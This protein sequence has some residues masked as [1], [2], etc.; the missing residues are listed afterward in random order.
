M[1]KKMLPVS[2]LT[3]LTLCGCNSSSAETSI[4]ATSTG[5]SST[6]LVSYSDYE[7][8]TVTDAGKD[9]GTSLENTILPT[10][11]SDFT[12]K[13][14]Y[15]YSYISDYSS[16]MTSSIQT[17]M[18]EESLPSIYTTITSAS[19]TITAPGD[20]YYS[21]SS[22]TD[23]TIT[24]ATAGSVHIYLDNATITAS[25][26]AIQVSGGTTPSLVTITALPNS[27]N[28]ITASEAKAKNA[29]DISSDLVVNGTGT[30]NVTSNN[31]CIKSSKTIYLKDVSLNL[32]A[33]ADLDGHG[34]SAETVFSDEATIVVPDAGK[35][36]IHAE[37]ADLLN[38]DGSF[39]LGTD[40]L[41]NS[42]GF[43]YLKD[44]DLTYKGTGDGVQADSYIYVDGGN[45]NITTYGTYVAYSS[46]LVSS[47]EYEAD[48]FK[49]VASGS[50]Y[51][52]VDSESRGKSGT[53]ALEESVKGFKV[54]T[55]DQENETTSTEEDITSEKYYLGV[56]NSTM[57]F[58]TADDALHVNYGYA[59]V[60][61]SD[62]TVDSLDQPIS[63]DGPLTVT[64]LK[65]KVNSSYEGMQGSTIIVQGSNT[66]L[67]IT[68][69]D[70]G[71]NAST[72]YQASDTTFYAE[73]MQLNDGYIK[74]KAGGDGLDSNGSLTINGGTVSVEGSSDANNSP[75]DSASSSENS[76]HNGIYVNGGTL[77]ASG[78]TG[79]LESP[80]Y[81]STQPSIVY[82][83]TSS[84]ASG[85]VLS[86]VDSN[87][88]V[89]VKNTLTK[90]AQGAIFSSPYLT[91]GQTYYVYVN[92]TSKGSGTISSM[93]TTI[94]TVNSN[95]SGGP[96]NGHGNNPGG[97]R[98]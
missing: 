86:L 50:S 45:Y 77:L 83:N 98:F 24:L 68:A 96:N 88:T 92:G 71:M 35:D 10:D 66:Y 95:N 58:N 93:V 81:T 4:S 30:I 72:D 40:D 33:K 63:S 97:G 22:F 59:N 28:T 21:G 84:L 11:N 23:I 53:Y 38:D 65:M 16:I 39:M 75:L 69:S 37:V 90:T 87:G 73:T 80:Q 7:E 51:K 55:M 31:N 8:P 89:L 56:I 14:G 12:A 25:K 19:S 34:I 41:V 52:K 64:N 2:L 76:L 17:L 44:T 15:S 18:S 43:V 78:S 42:V 20:Y 13:D 62:I 48:D 79:M 54:G 5:S 36:G 57:V 91:T 46:S 85:T 60:A 49:Y 29:I 3:V 61:C 82:G 9:D 6:S 67:D 47:G 26:K 27:T 74:V 32:S 1:K 94:G 70:D